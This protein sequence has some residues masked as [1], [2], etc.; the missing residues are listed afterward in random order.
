M[1][2]TTATAASNKK[3]LLKLL[4]HHKDSVALIES[5]LTGTTL[6]AAPVAAS[7][8]AASDAGSG[9]GRKSTKGIKRGPRGS[10]GFDLFKKRVRAEMA[11]KNPGVKFSLKEVADECAAR[12]AAGQYDE[13]YW[14]AQATALKTETS[15]AGGASDGES[16]AS[17]DSKKRGRPKG[18][19]NKAK[20]PAPAPVASQT[21]DE[22]AEEEIEAEVTEWT[23]KGKIY[24]KTD[25]NDVFENIDGTPG[26][27]LGTYNPL[28]DR[29]E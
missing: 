5:L 9:S 27:A 18:S 12:K 15:A 8:A 2:S 25:T 28:K 6:D 1:A 20:E 16:A 13:A 23:W 7:T 22:E 11:E 24:F 19:K 29:I 10:S 21:A 26:D 3:T 14:K 4:Q 17:S